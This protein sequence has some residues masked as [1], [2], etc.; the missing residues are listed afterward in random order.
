MSIRRHSLLLALALPIA[1]LLPTGANALSSL[2]VVPGSG[3]DADGRWIQ[4]PPPSAR[5]LH[6]AVYDSL[7]DRMIVIGGYST[8]DLA[9]DVWTLSL[10]GTPQ[11]TRLEPTG[12]P[13]S[14]RHLF[15]TVYD[16]VRDRILVFGGIDRSTGY[17]GDLWELSLGDAPAWRRLD[18]TG[19]GPSRRA[20]HVAIFDPLRDRMIVFGGF[21]PDA[22]PP[23]AVNEVWALSLGDASRWTLLTPNGTGPSPRT[24]ASGIYDPV[25][26]RLLVFGGRDGHAAVN[27]TWSLSFRGTLR[28]QEERP[29][30]SLP[31][32]RDHHSAIYDAGADRM[33]I[34]GGENDSG[35]PVAGGWALSLRGREQWTPVATPTT[36]SA[37]MGQ[38]AIYDPVRSRM[39]LYGGSPAASILLNE[40]WSL[41]LG[42]VPAWTN[43]TT[44]DAPPA[45][46]R[47]TSVVWD[48]SRHRF[49]LFGGNRGESES[50]LDNQVWSLAVSDRATW[51]LLPTK[52]VP[53]SGREGQSAIY[54]PA[55]DR[56]IVF[57]GQ[58]DA[59]TYS[60]EVWSL[61][62]AGDAQWTRLAPA[63]TAPVP[64][65]THTAIDDPI[66]ERM[67]V[68]GGVSQT[69]Y[70]D[71]VWTLS[72]SG[73][74]AWT[75]LDP[76]GAPPAARFEHSAIYD[77]VRRRM[78]VCGGLNFNA[79]TGDVWTLSLDGDSPAWTRL[80]TGGPAPDRFDHSAVYDPV[81]DR[82][83]VFGGASYSTA[84]VGVSTK[85]LDLRSATWSSLSLTGQDPRNGR[86]VDDPLNDRMLVVGTDLW[87]LD[88]GTPTGLGVVRDSPARSV[89]PATQSA[90]ISSPEVTPNPTHGG[91]TVSFTLRE[92][93]NAEV[94]V[95]DLGG[96]AIRTLASA[97]FSA[98]R[99]TLAWDGRTAAGAPALPGVYF[100]EIRTDHLVSTK[101]IVLV[102]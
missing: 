94:R 37:R 31:E 50:T 81:R 71:D 72:L 23:A 39:V 84:D 91:T 66:H 59:L 42:A 96:R 13:P 49:L 52:G 4:L 2:P 8:H 99:H 67:V 75:R 43:L 78:V 63:G 92:G 46:R 1:V 5:Y 73:P 14:A 86:A 53:P 57:G 80:V 85:A 76:V 30:G 18:P 35:S 68:F 90:E 61:S 6:G 20:Q 93:G 9:N 45:V 88:W 69:A 83:I 28:W 12:T 48:S 26:D 82:M 101:R 102:P 27:D 51:T 32:A 58:V 60:D 3:A 65:T 36:P 98:G 22:S 47:G 40:I 56:L 29:R 33:V 11:W 41:A 64:R 87:V 38:S 15:S 25:R 74:P 24:D 19:P 54:D 44:N 70:L 55:G 17:L 79:F 34:F 10:S 16:P 95:F 89:A 97:R 62:L 21:A 77:P 100:C 7:R